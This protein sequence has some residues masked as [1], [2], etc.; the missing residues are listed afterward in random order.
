MKLG[1][2]IDTGKT[3]KGIRG[4]TTGILKDYNLYFTLMFYCFF[5]GMTYYFNCERWFAVDQDDGKVE[6]EISALDT[7]LGFSQVRSF[8][9]K[10]LG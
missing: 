1:K 8:F 9:V 4:K 5:A 2:I 10:C 3:F 6:K 7:G